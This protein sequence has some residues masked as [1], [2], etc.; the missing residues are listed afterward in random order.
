MFNYFFRLRAYLTENAATKVKVA[1]RR[2]NTD[3]VGVI[4]HHS[5]ENIHLHDT[6]TETTAALK[7]VLFFTY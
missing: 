2:C 6:V 7:L 4:F 1:N 3:A 5:N